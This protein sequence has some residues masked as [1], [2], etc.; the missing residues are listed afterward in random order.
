MEMIAGAFQ[1]VRSI[2]LRVMITNTLIMIRK[3][4]STMTT[5]TSYA[6]LI[7]QSGIVAVHSGICIYC[8]RFITIHIKETGLALMRGI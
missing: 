8:R 3:K 4:I 6:N 2:V 5:I 1:P 7:L